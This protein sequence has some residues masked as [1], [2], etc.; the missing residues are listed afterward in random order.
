MSDYINLEAID[1]E[2]KVKKKIGLNGVACFEM[3]I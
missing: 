2:D 3:K 1:R